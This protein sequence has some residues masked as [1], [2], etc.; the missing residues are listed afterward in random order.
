MARTRKSIQSLNLHKFDVLIEDRSARSD[1]FKLSQFDGY[2]YGG[3]N[4]ILIGGSTV[5]RPRSKVLVEILNKDGSTVY[6]APVSTFIE[7]NSRLVQIEVYEDTPIGQGKIVILGC[8]DT[9]L[10][11]TP[12]PP[13]WKD[14]Y[15]VRWV[16]NVTISPLI[17]NKTP[18]LFITAPSMVV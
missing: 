4:S 17:E 6:S 11:G 15:N 12:V 9:L 14:K 10:D 13:A 18:I 7:G 16:G 5:L 1:Y 3:R 8:A 2:L